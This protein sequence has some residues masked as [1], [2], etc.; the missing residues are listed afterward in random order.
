MTQWSN[1]EIC[2][3]TEDSSENFKKVEAP[4]WLDEHLDLKSSRKP[5]MFARSLGDPPNT[6]RGWS[7]NFRHIIEH[8]VDFLTPE[9]TEFISF[10]DR[11]MGTTETDLE[12]HIRKC[13]PETFLKVQ[14]F[15]RTNNLKY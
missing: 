2:Q 4:S 7:K 13:W 12:W 14:N 1:E 15:V 6:Y 10:K 5:W 8:E 3:E 11:E 9:L